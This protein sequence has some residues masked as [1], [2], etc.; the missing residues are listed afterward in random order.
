MRK[1]SKNLLFRGAQFCAPL[2]LLLVIIAVTSL[3]RARPAEAAK[4]TSDFHA[5]SW[6]TRADL[7][8]H[9]KNGQD[10]NQI[11]YSE[12]GFKIDTRSSTMYLKGR[13][14]PINLTARCHGD[15]S[16]YRWWFWV[17]GNKLRSSGI[18][19]STDG[20]VATTKPLTGSYNIDQYARQ[21]VHAPVTRY[22]VSRR[23]GFIASK[24]RDLTINGAKWGIS[25]YV[26]DLNSKLLFLHF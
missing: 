6:K 19:W 23:G 24:G 7:V 9:L 2:L 16:P 15:D 10:S 25:F 11:R 26:I 1:F 8:K 5:F 18:H 12:Y 3:A 22:E 17:K 20:F 4:K 13:N 21:G 14:K